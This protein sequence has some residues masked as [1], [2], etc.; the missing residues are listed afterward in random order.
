[1]L[2]IGANR[3]VPPPAGRGR[4]DRLPGRLAARAWQRRSAGTGSKAD[5]RYSWA[6]IELSPEPADPA[7]AGRHYLL[8]RRHDRTGELA[9]LHC[10]SPQPATLGELIGS[11]ASGGAEEAGQAANGRTGLD[12]HQA[13]RWTS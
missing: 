5:R 8:V 2:Q 10:Y 1:M 3:W 6:W 7:D 9:Y 11:P 4:V 12:Q 13:R